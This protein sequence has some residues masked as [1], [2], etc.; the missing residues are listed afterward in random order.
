MPSYIY[1]ACYVLYHTISYCLYGHISWSNILL[2]LWKVGCLLLAVCPLITVSATGEGCGQAQG[3]V[4]GQLSSGTALCLWALCR[5]KWVHRQFLKLREAQTGSLPDGW[6]NEDR[7]NVIQ[8]GALLGGWRGGDRD[9]VIQTGTLLGGWRGGDRDNVIQTGTLVGDWR[10]GDR[11]N[12]YTQCNSDCDII[13]W[14]K[15]WGQGQC[16]SD[17]D[18]IGW[19][20][21]WGQGQ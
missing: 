20:K 21:R 4:P 2:L 10:G 12:N 14:L 1:L 3:S 15:R 6:R 19:L 7:D 11:D 5:G 8:T 13:R 16:N 9:N 18:I 17:W